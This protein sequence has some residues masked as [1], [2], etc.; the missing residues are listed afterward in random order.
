MLFKLPLIHCKVVE[1][2]NNKLLFD[3]WQIQILQNFKDPDCLYPFIPVEV[4][5]KQIR[6]VIPI[7]LG[8]QVKILHT[9]YLNNNIPCKGRMEIPKSSSNAKAAIKLNSSCRAGVRSSIRFKHSLARSM[10]LSD[11]SAEE[12][13]YSL[14]ASKTSPVAPEHLIR[15]PETGL[16]GTG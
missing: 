2:N 7:T 15:G 4:G 6:R 5:L 16:T 13:K 12:L 3:F 8:I 9:W 14:A 1:H 11:R 10:T